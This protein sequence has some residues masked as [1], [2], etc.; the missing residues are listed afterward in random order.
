MTDDNNIINL[1]APYGRKKD[2]TPKKKPGS[3]PISPNHPM[4]KPAQGQTWGDVG[5]KPG[6][7]PALGAAG[8]MP[9]AMTVEKRALAD[10]NKLNRERAAEEAAQIMYEKMHHAEHE[11]TQL[12]AAKL[13]R[14]MHEGTPIA[15]QVTVEV[16]DVRGLTVEFVKPSE[17]EN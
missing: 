1:E 12:A 4:Y 8:L 10:R 6:Y 9:G 14:E 16:D 13:V 7:R 15:R 2:G 17:R 3:A 11:T 5:R